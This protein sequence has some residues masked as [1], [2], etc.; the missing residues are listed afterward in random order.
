VQLPKRRTAIDVG[1]SLSLS[2]SVS[3]ANSK[4]AGRGAIVSVTSTM[5]P[6][7]GAFASTAR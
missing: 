6:R 7:M 3:A 2:A 5:P 1:A 4:R